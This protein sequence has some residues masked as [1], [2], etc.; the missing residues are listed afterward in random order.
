MR[1]LLISNPNSTSQ[2]SALFR[3]VLP[4]IRDVEGLQLLA[5]FTHYPGHA[6]D[7]VRGMTREDFDVIL[8]FGGDGTVN[9]VVNGLL[10][11]ADS[12][13]RPSPPGDSSTR[14]DPHWFR[15]C[16]RSRPWFPQYPG[17]GSARVGSD[18]GAQYA[19]HRLLRRVE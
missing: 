14:S 10:G 6:Q 15:Q 3:E 5:R 12:T 13:E 17:R 2:N 4:V 8:V 7:M 9:E 1:V 11:P 16:L 18:A 19:S